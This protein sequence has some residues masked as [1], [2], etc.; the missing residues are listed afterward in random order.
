[1][2]A[3]TP[4]EALAAGHTVV[5]A[6]RRLSRR[7]R[8]QWDAAQRSGGNEV[9]RSADAL[10]LEAWL[11][12]EWQRRRDW[13]SGPAERLLTARQARYLWARLLEDA[14]GWQSLL[15]PGQAASEAARA[16]G[17]MAAWGLQPEDIERDGS[18]DSRL[19]AD[20][21]RRFDAECRERG[22]VDA[23]RLPHRLRTADT[24]EG[25]PVCF[26]GFDRRP[27]AVVALV[28]SM[29]A[30]GRRAAW[31]AGSTS[32][33]C[34]AHRACF[35]DP[36]A[37]LRQAAAWA[38]DRLHRDAGAR[39]AVVVPDLEER[40]ADVERI[41]DDALSAAALVSPA[42]PVR[43]WSLSLG[44]PLADV[45]VVHIALI[46]LGLSGHARP[47]QEI[48]QLLRSPFLPDAVP[49]G[50]ARAVLDVRLREKGGVRLDLAGLRRWVEDDPPRPLPSLARR[51]ERFAERVAAMPERANADSWAGH[52]QA[53]LSALGWPGDGAPDSD[54]WQ[55]LE[56]WE[57]CLGELASLSALDVV[58]TR[59]RAQAELGSIVRERIFQPEGAEAS[60][61]VIGLLET[62]GLAFDGAWLTGAHDRALPLTLRPHPFLPA[63]LQRRLAMPRSCPG[64]EAAWA[65]AAI[66]RLERSAIELIV[67]WPRQVDQ[68]DVG[69]SPAIR[70]LP[71]FQ[72]EA[73]GLVPGPG[74]AHGI[75]AA[76]RD[77]PVV[78][79][80]LPAL[81][82]AESAGGTDVLKRQSDCPFQASAVYRLGCRPLEA[83]RPGI[84][85]RDRGTV[86]HRALERIWRELKT[87]DGLLA[88][89]PDALRRLVAGA[90]EAAGRGPLAATDAAHRA[91]AGLER[92]RQVTLILE[93]LAVE[94][95][96][97]P[98]EVLATE[99]AE[100]LAIGPLRL[101]GRVDR[102]D[103]IGE[104]TLLIDY[105]SGQAKEKHWF[106]DRP[107]QPQ[108]PAYLLASEAP[109]VGLAFGVLRAGEV[110]Y[111]GKASEALFAG[112]SG[113]DR[114]MP[115]WDDQR[116]A[117]REALVRLASGF[118]AGDARVDPRDR[119]V[120]KYCHLATLCRINDRPDAGLEDDDE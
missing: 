112:V 7:L 58:L 83:P 114:T 81:P 49:E 63:R 44:R 39:L 29:E 5:T 100:T 55:A 2:T 71:L 27:P 109:V 74:L 31:A 77:E 42:D 60:V 43:P 119:E 14:P 16:Y 45:P 97:P 75:L 69:P 107:E 99:E 106:G 66:E 87:R 92:E 38:A 53:A 78:D 18:S 108:L 96:R 51:L 110:G 90:V 20:L 1:M 54:T 59:A 111:R 85:P 24:Q 23:A 62:A 93:L 67:S 79:E 11:R 41:F 86:T 84:D 21:V 73:A 61:Q 95:R 3:H 19:F 15:L 117:W 57:E 40:R 50:A 88:L 65:T 89:A 68:Q 64:T 82:A 37:E 101:R 4:Q 33:P 12:R 13:R 105:K 118:A 35:A 56:A 46:A 102:R 52:F 103:R 72:P 17:L 6:T 94:A 36:V 104:G 8:Q 113:P 76:R 25:E 120:C 10:P 34:P 116:A 80:L 48:G 70:D 98:F 9:W 32:P 47:W 22:W 30:A 28:D 115:S 91:L 26:A